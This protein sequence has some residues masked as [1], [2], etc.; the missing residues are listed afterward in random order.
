MKRVT[1]LLAAI[2]LTSLHAGPVA[3]QGLTV[4]RYL[5][6][7]QHK[8]QIILF[9]LDTLLSG[10]S[11]ANERAKPRLYCFDIN[12]SGDSAFTVLDNRISTLLQQNKISADTPIDTLVM[13]MMLEEFPCK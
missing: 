8:D 12:R 5:A 13:D 9:Y 11:L 2:L 6:D 4:E 7:P 3:A 10:I 1:L